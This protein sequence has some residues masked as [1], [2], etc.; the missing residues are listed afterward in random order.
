M[1]EK[2][3]AW[4]KLKLQ[5]MDNFAGGRGVPYPTDNN[6]NKHHHLLSTSVKAESDLLS[7]L[8]GSEP[9]GKTG[10]VGVTAHGPGQWVTFTLLC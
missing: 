7:T 3:G 1:R 5:L 2:W 8:L 10:Q 6:L 4:S 9:V